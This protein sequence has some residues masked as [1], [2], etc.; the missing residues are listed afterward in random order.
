[1]A[2][3]HSIVNQP[4]LHSLY[5][6]KPDTGELIS[7]L[8][9]KPVGWKHNGYLVVNLW[10]EGRDKKFKVHQLI[11]MYVHGRWPDQVI[12]HIDGNRLNN[13]L[14]NL[15]EVTCQQNRQNNRR[16]NS[17]SGYMGV[18][19]ISSNNK[20]V[21]SIGVDKKVIYLGSFD[22][23]EKAHLEYCKAAQKYHTHNPWANS[24]N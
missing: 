13:K 24:K 22:D 12:D 10:H 20:Y 6:Y 19:K 9:S 16:V 18:H 11:W 21:A 4:R 8:Y 2:D 17:N 1:M 14:S 3:T 23:P 5:D 7:K 15:R